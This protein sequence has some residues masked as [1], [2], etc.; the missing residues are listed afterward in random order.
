MTDLRRAAGADWAFVRD[1]SALVILEEVEPAR[2]LQPWPLLRCVDLLELRNDTGPRDPSDVV[3]EFSARCKRAGVERL[4][5]DAHYRELVWRVLA[6]DDIGLVPAPVKA[7]DIAQSYLRLRGI[8]HARR[9]QLP[10]SYRLKKQLSDLRMRVSSAGMT[11]EHARKEGAHGDI[12]SAL[13]LAVWQLT[14]DGAA[15]THGSIPSR[16][17]AIDPRYAKPT[18]PAAAFGV[19]GISRGVFA[20][21]AEELEFD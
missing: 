13:V 7:E 17:G 21:T 6:D 20:D 11:P 9:L 5:S 12:V 8:L 14:A 4:M 18:D 10:E 19:E 3:R 1:A 16:T 15:Y 2:D